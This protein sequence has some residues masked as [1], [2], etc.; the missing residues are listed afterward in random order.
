MVNSLR[1]KE[2]NDLQI[3]EDVLV[4]FAQTSLRDAISLM[5]GI[6]TGSIVI[7][8]EENAPIG[9]FTERD[10]LKKYAANPENMS[11]DDPVSDYMTP[12]PKCVKSGATLDV[13]FGKMRLGN[14]RHLIVVDDDGK[15]K[16]I[17]SIKDAFNYVCDYISH[18]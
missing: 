4:C 8:D 13:A 7:I 6:N 5:S 16:G 1:F 3:T 18:A 15:L 10:F 2:I 11:M 17:V 14:F 9:I 12:S